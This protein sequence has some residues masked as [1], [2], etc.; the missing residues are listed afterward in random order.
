M[1]KEL[2]G[3]WSLHLNSSDSTTF[4]MVQ[5]LLRVSLE[6]DETVQCETLE[7]KVRFIKEQAT[8]QGPV[9]IYST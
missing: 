5:M 4:L 3:R 1:P 7:E 9:H 2:R 8:T 6:I